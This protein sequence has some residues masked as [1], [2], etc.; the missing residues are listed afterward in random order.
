MMS[1]PNEIGCGVAVFM[2]T[3]CRNN[4]RSPIENVT[5]KTNDF[6]SHYV[7]PTMLQPL[8]LQGRNFEYRRVTASYQWNMIGFVADAARSMSSIGIALTKYGIEKHIKIKLN[9]EPF[10]LVGTISIGIFIGKR[11]LFATIFLFFV[12]WFFVFLFF[13]TGQ[14]TMQAN[15]I[16][17]AVRTKPPEIAIIFV[18]LTALELFL[19]A[20]SRFVG[21]GSF[22]LWLGFVL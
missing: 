21:F 9:G 3:T 12:R 14:R 2:S 11:A 15:N 7:W 1:L 8:P 13:I 6:P 4:K 16:S 20:M 22:L 19:L 17:L 5:A 10:F 18:L